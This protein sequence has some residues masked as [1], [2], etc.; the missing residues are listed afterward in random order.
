MRVGS[1]RARKSWWPSTAPLGHS[2]LPAPGE[3]EA[4]PYLTGPLPDVLN[5]DR[6]RF[7]GRHT[8]VVG[9]GHSAANTLLALAELA[10]NEPGTRITWAMPDAAEPVTRHRAPAASAAGARRLVGRAS[11]TAGGPLAALC[12]TE[13]TSW[14]VLYYAFPVLAQDI[15]RD[16][17]WSTA[18]ITAAFSAAL[19]V[20]ALAGI[21]VGRALDRHGPRALM[22]GGSM[23]AVLAA[24]L[25]AGTAPPHAAIADHRL[26]TP[27]PHPALRRN[28]E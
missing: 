6:D 5:R 15:T 12:V 11:K 7:A 10:E 17:G 25:A 26:A 19:I 4:A 24:L 20:A 14:G 21:P 27:T 9:M 23:L 3:Q 16:T 18:T 22:T 28:Q 13:I 8:L 1:P 2:G